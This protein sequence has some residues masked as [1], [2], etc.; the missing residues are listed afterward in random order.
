MV[1][2]M[3]AEMQPSRK[4]VA[5]RSHETVVKLRSCRGPS[6]PFV[7]SYV[8]IARNCSNLTILRLLDEPFRKIVRVDRAK[9]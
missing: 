3:L 4:I 2:K 7:R 9:L 5:C 1:R 6:N 8:S